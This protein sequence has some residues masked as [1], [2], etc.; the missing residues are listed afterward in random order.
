[1]IKVSILLSISPFGLSA[2]TLIVQKQMV[3]KQV[4]SYVVS[5][6][7]SVRCVSV[8]KLYPQASHS[9]QHFPI[10]IPC[11]GTPQVLINILIYLSHINKYMNR[12][13][14]HLV[15]YSCPLFQLA[16]AQHP[17]KDSY[18]ITCFGFSRQHMY[19]KVKLQYTG[20]AHQ[21]LPEISD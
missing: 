21:T 14:S 12:L 1:M 3:G 4:L 20:I 9:L 13:F 19:E 2:N 8:T 10:S 7:D 11:F 6:L 18:N 5:T 15:I 16:L 17:G